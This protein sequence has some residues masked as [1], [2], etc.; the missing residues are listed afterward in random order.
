MED[1]T[2]IRFVTEYDV[3]NKTI[4]LGRSMN[5]EFMEIVDKMQEIHA[6]KSAD[7]S[8]KGN[9]DENFERVALI[10]SWF[11]NPI[12]RAFAGFITVKL[13]RLATLLNNAHSNPNSTP[14]NES[15][16]DSFLD[17]TTY[18]A[19]W[20]ANVARRNDLHG[21]YK[22]HRIGLVIANCYFCNKPILQDCIEDVINHTLLH[23]DCIP[24]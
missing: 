24:K 12:D 3:I 2:K 18:S 22:A 1:L 14:N 15:L 13:A 21:R 23:K 8:V 7:Y 20:G 6:K 11:T 10:Q 5:K 17:M 16:A 9:P 19:L 4:T